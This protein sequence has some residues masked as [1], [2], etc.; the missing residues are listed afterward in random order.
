MTLNEFKTWSLAQGQVG[1]YD[2]GQYVGQCVSLV[3][4]YCYRVLDVP[5]G[6]WGH[7][8]AWANNNNPNRQYFDKVDSLQ[9]GDVIVYG[10]DF[11]P[12]YGHIGIAVGGGVILDQNG[13]A[14]LHVA[15]GS[16]YNGY[17]CILRKKGGNVP[18]FTSKPI[19]PD[20]VRQHLANFTNGRVNVTASDPVCQNR[21]EL[22]DENWGGE[23][24]KGLNFQQLDIIRACDKK[25]AE[26]EKQI[27]DGTATG[28]E[29]LTDIYV[30]KG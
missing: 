1:K 30:K 22:N 3:N 26:L 16:I 25:I 11:T 17:N 19:P 15:T 24:W 5:A 7:A 4:Q 14:V 6:A 10:T 23:F 27:A 12:L 29:K 28:Y 21:F 20:T 18:T 9:A 2:D 13:R 8:Y